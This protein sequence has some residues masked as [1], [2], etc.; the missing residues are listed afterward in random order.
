MKSKVSLFLFLVITCVL[1]SFCLL[2]ASDFLSQFFFLVLC[3]YF[4]YS[5]FFRNAISSLRNSNFDAFLRIY[6]I[7]KPGSYLRLFFFFFLFF[8]FLSTHF[9]FVSRAATSEI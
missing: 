3:S 4:P 7:K 6:R 9:I 5:C 2:F 1:F 8:L